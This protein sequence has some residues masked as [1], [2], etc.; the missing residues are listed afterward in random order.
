MDN[1]ESMGQRY[2]H[3]VIFSGLLPN[4]IYSLQVKDD[5]GVVLKQANYKTIPSQ[6]AAELKMAVGGDLGMTQ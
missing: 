2:V 1:V 3:S 6:D 4:T 5:S